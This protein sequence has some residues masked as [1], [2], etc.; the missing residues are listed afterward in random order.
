MLS[1]DDA[2]VLPGKKTRLAAYVERDAVLGMRNDLVK[3]PVRF[4]IDDQEVG[5]DKTDDDGRASIKSRVSPQATSYEAAA[6]HGRQEFRATGRVFAWD[7]QRVVIAV[8]LDQTIE[9]TEYKALL[10]D[11]KADD[12]DPLKRSVAALRGL[13]PDFHIVY[14][15]GRPRFLLEKTRAWLRERGFPEGPVVTAKGVREMFSPGSF[16][17]RKLEGLRGDWPHLLIGIGDKASDANAY[18]ANDM[19]SLIVST[20]HDRSFPPHA[21]VFRDWKELGRFFAANRDTLREPRAL[22]EAI[23]GKRMLQLTVSKYREP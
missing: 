15:T 16:K 6:Q 7:P 23:D 17:E 22:R 5:N 18:G 13:G 8:D 9:R 19:L 1:V 4:C 2:V 12:S 3:V 21:L 14:L 20:E 10:L 11:S